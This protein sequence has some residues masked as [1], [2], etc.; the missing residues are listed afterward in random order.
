MPYTLRELLEKDG[1]IQAPGCFD[2]LTA[3]VIQDVGFDA[4]YLG[5][6]AMGSSNCLTEPMM[7]MSE[8]VKAAE[9]VVDAIKIPLIVDAGAGYGDANQVMRAVREFKKV[10]V[11]AVHIEDQV[12]PKRCHYHA[13]VMGVVPRDEML[14]RI[15]AAVRARGD[16]DFVIIA[17]TDSRNA[18]N[19]SFEEWKERCKLMKEAGA[20]VIMPYATCAQS[21]EEARMIHDYIQAPMLYVGSEGRPQYPKL[22]AKQIEEAGFK[23]VIWNA[24]ST[25]F[26]M[27]TLYDNMKHLKE[28]GDSGFSHEAFKPVRDRIESLVG[29]NEKYQIEEEFNQ[30]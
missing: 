13:G 10:G 24:I 15:K 30:I 6:Y 19:S 25:F 23:I 28:F 8:V 7:T 26:M 11:A 21:A 16:D 22:T 14:A 4:C 17:R 9:Y 3:R 1:I 2:A 20:D 12:Y 18:Y 29:L 5:G 27:N